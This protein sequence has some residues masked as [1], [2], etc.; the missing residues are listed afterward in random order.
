MEQGYSLSV[1][2]TYYDWIRFWCLREGSLM[3][4]RGYLFA[5]PDFSKDV[6]TFDKISHVPCLAL[7]GE[8]GIGKTYALETEIGNLKRALSNTQEETLSFNLR[9][10]SSE[11][12]L[13]NEIFE[14]ER[15]RRWM[16]GSHILHLFLDS[17]DEGLLRIDT[18]A[19]LL[20]EKLKGLPI[21]RLKF[22][23]ACRTA[24]WSSFLETNLKSLWGDDNFRA[25]ELAPLQIADV[26]TAAKADGLD[27]EAFLS[28]VASKN[29]EPLAAKPVTLRLLL[30]LFRVHN[31]LPSSQSELY[32]RGC[33]LLCEEESEGR[34]GKWK[35]T[36]RQRFRLAARIAAITI[37]GNRASIWI[38]HD[39]GEQTESDVMVNEL[40][41][42][43]EKN[44]DG[45]DLH[46]TEDAIQETI[47]ATGLFTSRGPNRLG[48]QH[49]TYAE[50][51]AA[52]YLDVNL[53]D[54]AILALIKSSDDSEGFLIPQLY[55][56]AAWLASKRPQVFKN[57]METEPLVLLRSDVLSA[58]DV[59]RAELTSAL[60]K[61]FEDEKEFD[62][63]EIRSYYSKLKHN[64]MA[65]QLRPYLKD[66]SK[67][68]LVRR[69]AVDIAEE[70]VVKELQND[71]ADI[72]LDQTEPPSTRAN[73]ARAVSEIGDSQTRARLKPLALGEAGE[74]PESELKGYGL[75][76]VWPEHMSASELFETLT[77][78][79]NLYGSYKSFLSRTL[80]PHL[81]TED[82]PVALDWVKQATKE[83]G[84]FDFD[85]KALSSKIILRA[86]AALDDERVLNSFV[87]VVLEK[88]KRFDELLEESDA[89]E[90][91][92][93]MRQDARKRRR[94]LLKLF[95]LLTERG[96]LFGLAD[97]I[98]LR[99]VNE[100]VP[101][102][103]DELRNTH[104]DRVKATVLLILKDF[105]NNWHGVAPEVLTRIHSALD[106][107]DLIRQEF[108]S[109]FEPVHLDSP[110]IQKAR[111]AYERTFV[112]GKAKS[113]EEEEK[114]LTPTPAE[115]VLMML[116]KFE[117]GDIDA[118]WQLN[119]EMTLAEGSRFYGNELEVDLT[120]LPGWTNANEEIKQRIMSAAR[121]YVLKGNPKTEE[122]IG[123]NTLYRPAFSG[124]RALWL[125][126]DRDP[127]FIES[128]STTVWRTWAPI[129]FHYPIYNGSGEEVY[130]RHRQFIARAY[131]F[132]PDEVVRL[133]L[134]EIDRFGEPNTT[135]DFDKL[136]G[137]WDEGLSTALRGKLMDNHLDPRLF[138]RILAALI[139]HNDQKTVSY[140]R[141]LLAL[142]I[143]SEEK[144]RE[145][146][147]AAATSLLL[148]SA[149]AGWD[150]VWPAI[151]SNSEFGRRVI[152]TFMSP[153]RRQIAKQLTELQVGDFYLWLAQQY[154]HSEDPQFPAG[155]AHFV[156]AREEIAR[157]RDSLL[158]HL[159]ERGTRDSVRVIERIA[160]EL[161]HLD[162]LKWTLLEAKKNMR[163]HLWKPLLPAEVIALRYSSREK[164][165]KKDT[166]RAATADALTLW[167]SPSRDIS[168][169]DD[170]VAT[171]RVRPD[172]FA[173]FVGAG[174]AAPVF[175]LWDEVL[176]SLI[177]KCDQKKVLSSTDRDEL[178]ESLNQKK[179]FLDIAATCVS[180]L[181][182]HDYR[183][184][185]EEQFDRE[186][187]VSKLPAYQELFRLRPNTIVTTNFDQI[188]ERLN[189][190]SF[191][192]DGTSALSAGSYYR[193]F[194]NQNVPE[195]NNAWKG[196]KPIVFK[197]HGC[198]T[199]H[200]SIVFTRSDFRRAIYHGPVNGF[201]D[202]IFRSRTVIFLGF[203]FSDP[204]IDS[205]LSFLQEVNSGLGSPHYVL[206]HDLTNIQRHTLERNYG[207][208]IINYSSSPGHLQVIEFIRLLRELM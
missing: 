171:F 46:V 39:T 199:D 91:F 136:E 20:V 120:Q 102:L 59:V 90:K 143:A 95:P 34:K 52:W 193:V 197:M 107:N 61:V 50:F 7:L 55:E 58:D 106:Q 146:S 37:F 186:V 80:I 202:A 19:A 181:E 179:D 43:F 150:S 124:Y 8:P 183:A 190:L 115:R 109:F 18:L 188:P 177:N 145:R 36:A 195:A 67:G 135:V 138:S 151:T 70:C 166:D 148:F 126:R 12:R 23:I 110:D 161:P 53:D 21:Q 89:R 81:K 168:N 62:R 184:F 112:R 116:T 206:T 88:I 201:L 14:S 60:L 28:D 35:L 33:L 93:A 79:P 22:R 73:A 203:G 31:G 64:A 84:G 158:S 131:R 180:V 94:L 49:Q 38:G 74:D 11:L 122:W 165:I 117:S 13:T 2:N 169:L 108:S 25:Y 85:R 104:N 54:E 30:N 32:E 97:S 123:T 17:L 164:P 191:S 119:L 98:L 163:R 47:S 42:V 147:L 29:A 65:G 27:S 26:S 6:V 160:S 48:W 121:A 132:V 176:S 68:F 178:I 194:T 63:W 144:A 187:D 174:L 1:P 5:H 156:G 86:W 103:L 111:E 189:G 114:P 44:P 10:F 41:G 172:G 154:P 3:L 82:L 155:V 141:D 173:F 99:I 24:E 162:W 152:E 76:C 137:C 113:K 16:V 130:G 87:E 133:L 167:G 66:K 51:L 157:L 185:I 57:L 127:S 128:L 9:S 105:L 182:K 118:W 71:L 69:V 56:T 78:E 134:Q 101:W 15:F 125:L 96:D 205:I 4:G 77:D 139:E 175:P 83:S 75:M 192:L 140:A 196:G 92:L 198:V 208:N 200:D 142:P 170:L 129:I 149:D 100:D 207:V 153:Y 204:H 40:A 45:T 72:A 159:K